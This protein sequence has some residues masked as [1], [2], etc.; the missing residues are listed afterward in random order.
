MQKYSKT[1]IKNFV[2]S[3]VPFVVVTVISVIF[4]NKTFYMLMSQSRKIYQLQTQSVL[5]E[6]D[7]EFSVSAQ[8]AKQIC[9]D[10]ALSR[11][12]LLENGRLTVAAIDRMIIYGYKMNMNPKIFLTYS[13]QQI[14]TKSGTCT[15]SVFASSVLGLSQDSVEYWEKQMNCTETFSSVILE[16]KTGEHYLLLLYYYPESRYIQEKRIGFVFS[17]SEMATIIDGIVSSLNGF[18][19]LT[20]NEKT[21]TYVNKTEESISTPSEVD[22][23]L[24]RAQN[25]RSSYTLLHN[26]SD[27][28]DMELT[29]VIDNDVVR[30]EL[31]RE[32]I[33]MVAIG[34]ITFLG[35]FIFIWM[36]TN[37]RY[38]SLNDLK[39]TALKACPEYACEDTANEYEIVKSVLERNFLELKMKSDSIESLQ[40]SSKRQMSWLLLCAPAPEDLDVSSLLEHYGIDDEGYYYCVLEIQMELPVQDISVIQKSIPEILLHCVVHEEDGYSLV[41]GLSLRDRDVSGARRKQIADEI[42]NL[43]SDKHIRCLGVSSGLVYENIT[44]LYISHKE[45]QTV[46]QTRRLPADSKN[47]L[48]FYDMIQMKGRLNS[49]VEGL[50]DQFHDA[51]SRED[52][53]SASKVFHQMLKQD[54]NETRQV[55]VRYKVINIMLAAMQETDVSASQMDDLMRLIFLD[56]EEFEQKIEKL[57][58]QMYTRVSKRAS[59]DQVLD[60]IRNSYTDSEICMRKVAD[61]FGIS[62]R[63]VTRIIKKALG[64]TYKEYV[65]QLRMEQVCGLLAET[66]SD[67]QTIIKT[68]G[69]YDVSSFNRLFKKLYGATPMEYRISQN[70]K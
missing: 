63:S 8:V 70:Q 4:L 57:L 61:Q 42:I 67:I 12:R 50:I 59:D 52:V 54:Q 44:Q 2:A 30:G 28:Y 29:V 24:H 46:L 5:Y 3:F 37:R 36:Y 35:L 32:E 25:A 45:S 33:L 38:R 26:C 18:A 68:V 48:F 49:E 60:Y 15:S 11:E 56:G 20:W 16:S 10:S 53:T 7:T 69:Y 19:T 43:L 23:I 51:L 22:E 39:Q 31:I 55:Y 13:P 34:L 41:L 27:F 14:A 66:S 64:L 62:E 65:T 21:L 9:L 58:I 6:M 17:E 1:F 47:V 40:N